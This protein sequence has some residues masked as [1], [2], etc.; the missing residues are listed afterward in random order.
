LRA[1]RDFF[2]ISAAT[3]IDARSQQP[4][5]RMPVAIVNHGRVTFM[6]ITEGTD[7]D[8]ADRSGENAVMLQ[9]DAGSVIA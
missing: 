1:N 6:E 9:G 3:V 7:D 5:R 2:P 4:P 8:E